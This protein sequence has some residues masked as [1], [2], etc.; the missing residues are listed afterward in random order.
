MRLR[1]MFSLLVVVAVGASSATSGDAVVVE[2]QSGCVALDSGWVASSRT[3][4]GWVSD[5]DSY[6][7]DIRQH[8]N[9]P[10]LPADSVSIVTDS[11]TCARAALAYGRN[12]NVPDTTTSRQVFVV[13]VGPTRYIVVDPNVSNGEFLINMVF[14]SSFSTVFATVAH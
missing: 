8:L 7:A 14:D 12:L 11:A 6:S 9:L 3:D 2:E 10:H 13:R 5:T 1:V 4:Q